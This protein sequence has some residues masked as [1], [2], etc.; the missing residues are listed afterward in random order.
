MVVICF[1]VKK[2]YVSAI[3]FS[4]DGSVQEE[5]HLSTILS[6]RLRQ[7]FSPDLRRDWTAVCHHQI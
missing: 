3:M 2:A 5:T 7:V 1:Q 6:L 4:K